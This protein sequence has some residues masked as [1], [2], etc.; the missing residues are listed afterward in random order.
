MTVRETR[1]VPIGLGRG[2]CCLDARSRPGQMFSA[3]GGQFLASFPE[4]QRRIEIEATLFEDSNHLDQFVA[5]LFVIQFT[6]GRRPVRLI[7]HGVSVRPV[8]TAPTAPSESRIRSA[9]P[10]GASAVERRIDTEPDPG[11][12]TRWTTA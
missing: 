3:A 4:S 10:A 11:S 9:T 1:S 12:S 8:L 5:A 6:D 2:Q 7:A